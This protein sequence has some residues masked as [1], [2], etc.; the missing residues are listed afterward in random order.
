MGYGLV[1]Y[2][3]LFNFDFVVVLN[4]IYP[5]ISRIN[6]FHKTDFNHNIFLKFFIRITKGSRLFNNNN[7]V[8]QIRFAV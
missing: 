5:L 7:D 6:Y 4:G 8:I 1:L 3:S 2:S